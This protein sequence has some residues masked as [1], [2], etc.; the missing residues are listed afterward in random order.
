[1]LFSH[2]S[3]RCMKYISREAALEA[4]KKLFTSPD[5]EILTINEVFLSVGRDLNRI[6]QNKKWLTNRLTDLKHY[7]FVE[8]VYTD[9]QPK[10]LDKIRL[11]PAGKKALEDMLRSQPTRNITL[12]SI[13][14]DVQEFQKQNPSILVQ[15]TTT[16]RE[17]D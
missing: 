13:A 2:V 3:I 7:N 10:M 15:L 16:L 4:L 12:E 14:R 9:T 17:R 11:L 1:M 5:K 6:E 8:S